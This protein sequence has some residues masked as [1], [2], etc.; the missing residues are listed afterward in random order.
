M[1]R[2]R[3]KAMLEKA[4]LRMYEG[5][6]RVARQRER[7]TDM[8][9][10]GVDMRPYWEVLAQFEETQR[11]HVQHVQRLK[12][13]LYDPWEP[14]GED[15][16]DDAMPSDKSLS[17]ITSLTGDN[18]GEEVAALAPAESQVQGGDADAARPDGSFHHSHD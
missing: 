2:R 12:K 18:G 9:S 1:D 4:E 6:W 15:Y 7:I 8:S 17:P 14:K 3:L 16:A 13:E 10:R 5:A 11:L